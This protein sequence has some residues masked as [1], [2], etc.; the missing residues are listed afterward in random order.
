MGEGS[1]DESD[2]NHKFFFDLLHIIS[3]SYP[4][5]FGGGGGNKPHSQAYRDFC[6]K[7]GNLKTLYEISDEKAG[8][9]ATVYQLYL[10][11]Y[12]TFLSYLIDK[13]EAEREEDKF[14][15]QLRKLKKGRH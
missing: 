13:Q 14:Q 3:D 15:D 9:I 5:V 7:W 1:S 4:T 6:A 8:Q 12:L 11:D 10:N 2:G